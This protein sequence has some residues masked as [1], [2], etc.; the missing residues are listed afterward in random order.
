MHYI[1]KNCLSSSNGG[2]KNGDT[3]DTQL[4]VSASFHFYTA[5]TGDSGTFK[6]QASNDTYNA[7]NMAGPANFQPTNWVDIPNQ[8]A[9]ITSGGAALLTIAN[10]SY[11]WLRAVYTKSAGTDA[12]IVNVMAIYP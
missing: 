1:N 5:S 7:N 10:C 11:R 8:S 6:L 12:V 2:T 3:L 4:W 9:S